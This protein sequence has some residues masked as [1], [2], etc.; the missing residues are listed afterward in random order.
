MDRSLM[1]TDCEGQI[2]AINYSLYI[3]FSAFE[4]SYIYYLKGLICGTNKGEKHQHA[5]MIA[6][7]PFMAIIFNYLINNSY[8]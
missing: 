5:S 7:I 1:C 8:N 2:T 3:V 4:K 6:L